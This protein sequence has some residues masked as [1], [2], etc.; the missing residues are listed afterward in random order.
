MYNLISLSSEKKQF[1]NLEKYNMTNQEFYEFHYGKNIYAISS[2]NR[3][4][5]LSR[6]GIFY[7]QKDQYYLIEQINQCT[8]SD[9]NFYINKDKI[10]IHC[11]Y[12]PDTI[13]EYTINKLNLKKKVYHLNFDEVPNISKLHL[14][15]D[16]VVDD[17]FYL[18]STVKNNDLIKEGNRI[19]CLMKNNTCIYDDGYIKHNNKIDISY[20]LI[21]EEISP[22]QKENKIIYKVQ[23]YQNE[24]NILVIVTSN[25][26]FGNI[27]YT[28][29]S[30]RKINKNN[31]KVQ[32]TSNG[33]LYTSKEDEITEVAITIIDNNDRYTDYSSRIIHFKEK[34]VH[35]LNNRI[36]R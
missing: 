12:N 1:S 28:V 5:N 31:I 22:I 25:S 2:I 7:K 34:K 27:E 3:E 4:D 13:L 23:I 14:Q 16:A 35:I 20:K 6:V 17:Y 36:I 11:Y 24:N 32:W 10:Y 8:F 21:Y 18:Y 19:K 9:N 15:F 33:N 29:K 26:K 30:N